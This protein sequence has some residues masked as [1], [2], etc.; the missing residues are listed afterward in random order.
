MPNS[1]VSIF[2]KRICSA[3]RKTVE[4]GRE[5]LQFL[6]NDDCR[7]GMLEVN[8]LGII[9]C[10]HN[11]KFH[12]WALFGANL[13]SIWALF[14]ISLLC[15]HYFSTTWAMFGVN[16]G[17]I[18]VYPDNLVSVLQ[19]FRIYLCPVS[20][21]APCLGSTYCL[22][23]IF[24]IGVYLG[25]IWVYSASTHYWGLGIVYLGSI[26]ATFSFLGDLYLLFALFSFCLRSSF[27]V[28]DSTWDSRV[29]GRPV[30]G[31]RN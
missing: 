24:A 17:S 8:N 4:G 23:S 16:L 10:V 7:V 20:L 13:S 5:M 6:R 2:L 9:W 19:Y 30:W 18:R 15:L 27:T 14:G 11:L 28:W 21:L 29:I 22:G 25:K 3:A 12:T 1:R 31:A 26:W